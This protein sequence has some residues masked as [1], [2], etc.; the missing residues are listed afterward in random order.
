MHFHR[1]LR[2]QQGAGLGSLFGGLFRK[3]VPVAKT[4]VKSIG[5]IAKNKT[6]RSA[7]NFIKK[8]ATKAAIDTALEALDGKKNLGSS[9][10]NRLKNAT[11]KI[12]ES[13]R[14][15]NLYSRNRGTKRKQANQQNWNQKRRRKRQT[16]P[17]FDD[18][19]D[20]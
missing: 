6:I 10:K 19:D 8:E 2:V 7:G 17:L 13:Q 11:R 4:A 12:L 9:A 18:Y 1:G 14:E 5:K 15:Q 3:L 16:E 20:E